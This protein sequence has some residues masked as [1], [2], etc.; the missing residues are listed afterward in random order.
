MAESKAWGWD[1]DNKIAPWWEEPAGEMYPVVTRWKEN[2][3]K[4]LLDLGC[5]IGRHAVLSAQVGL[6]VT[7]FDLSEE[8]LKK[9]NQVA[10]EKE[11]KIKTVVGDMVKLPFPDASFDSVLAF[12]AIYHQDDEGLKM[13]VGEIKRVLRVGGE[14]YLTFNSKNSTSFKSNDVERLSPNTIVKTKGHEAGIPHFYASK[15]EVEEMLKGF[16]MIEFTYKEEYYP[17]YV[18]AHY[19][20]LAKK[21]V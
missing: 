7:A 12:H 14:A 18:G 20:V 19:F 17:D 21:K 9:L 15:V 11:L 3:Y 13:V 1:W 16:E 4:K 10:K 5:G 2:G 8:G 6:D